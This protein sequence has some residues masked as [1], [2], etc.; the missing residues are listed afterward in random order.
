MLAIAPKTPSYVGDALYG[1]K[2]L[3]RSRSLTIT[4]VPNPLYLQNANQE[5]TYITNLQDAAIQRIIFQDTYVNGGT[6]II[7]KAGA[8]TIWQIENQ[9]S[10]PL[11]IT[12]IARLGLV[13][14]LPD[15]V[16]KLLPVDGASLEIIV[17][18][19]KKTLVVHGTVHLPLT[20]DPL[21]INEWPS[22]P[23]TI[24]ESHNVN[25][26]TSIVQK[27]ERSLIVDMLMW[28][29]GTNSTITYGFSSIP[30]KSCVFIKRT[31]TSANG[32][33]A[34]FTVALTST[35]ANNTSLRFLVLPMVVLIEHF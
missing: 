12:G 23:A 35:V 29:R 20:L 11:T 10:K 1:K 28:L 25:T 22:A 24:S 13:Q 6:Q 16:V 33:A 32:S 26:S 31:S 3:S 17:Q 7:E 18:G 2:G 4:K 15:K 19:L 21:T 5:A 30:T 14:V 34:T 27:L 8:D 9:C